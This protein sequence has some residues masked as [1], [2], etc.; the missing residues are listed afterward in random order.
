MAQTKKSQMNETIETAVELTQKTAQTT[1]KSAVQTVEL[2]EEYVQGLYKVGYDTNVGALKVAK[3]YW[4]AASQI[5]QDWVKLFAQTGEYLIDATAK[6]EL[7]LQ[8]EIAD[9]GK[10]IVSNVEKT[11]ENFTPQAKTTAK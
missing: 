8:K 5:R 1:L 4:D 6:M 10:G 2:T 11:V 7:P 9:F 3:N